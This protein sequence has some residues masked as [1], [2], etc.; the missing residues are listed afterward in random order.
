VALSLPDLLPLILQRL[1]VA[2][3]SRL[4]VSAGPGAARFT[5]HTRDFLVTELLLGEAGPAPPAGGGSSR[6][7]LS[8]AVAPYI[9]HKV[10]QRLRQ[11]GQYYA[12]A[13]GN[14]WLEDPSSGMALLVT[15]MRSRKL[16]SATGAAFQ[17][18]GLRLLFH[19]LAD[20][21]LLRCS[22]AEVA[23]QTKVPR[24]VTTE[25]SLNLAQQGFLE[26]WNGR[27]LV[28][29][30][31][32]TAR[33]VVGYRD[34]LRPRLPTQRY[35][36]VTGWRGKLAWVALA[37]RTKSLLGGAVAARRLLKCD[38]VPTTFTLYHHSAEC[39]ALLRSVGLEP[40]PD[41]PVEVVHL[42]NTPVV[43]PKDYCVH[44]LFI[45]AELMVAGDDASQRVAE[46]ILTQY[47]PHLAV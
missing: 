3:G 25:T 33:W 29:L 41:G 36:W 9:S 19:L 17:L 32:L 37:R 6:A 46:R 2:L 31:A 24:S 30:A 43:F 16:P 39:L 23:K 8:I 26:V 13:M 44:P 38:L 20:P 15:G 14:V 28:N 4:L 12:D 7:P 1:R 11:Q 18:Q 10:A 47:L 22:D 5:V 35:R 34:V 40:H 42:F 27:R 21:G 45:Y